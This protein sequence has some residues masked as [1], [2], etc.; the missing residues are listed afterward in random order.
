MIHRTVIKSFIIILA[1]LLCTFYANAGLSQTESSG[2]YE[3]IGE[4]EVSRDLSVE[5]KDQFNRTVQAVINHPLTPLV[6]GAI[7]V[8]V[9][10]VLTW[11]F[12]CGKVLGKAE[13]GYKFEPK[14]DA[15]G[16]SQ[17]SLE[18]VKEIVSGRVSESLPK[19][20]FGI[21]FKKLPK[22]N[23]KGFATPRRSLWTF[24]INRVD[25]NLKIVSKQIDDLT[26]ELKDVS[27]NGVKRSLRARLNSAFR[28][29]KRLENERETLTNWLEVNYLREQ[30][31]LDSDISLLTDKLK[32]TSDNSSLQDRFTKQLQELEARK[33]NLL[34]L[35]KFPKALEN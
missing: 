25:E 35:M 24:R 22:P 10:C 19:P 28:L 23:F 30:K 32:N 13:L 14:L 2:D 8:G 1:L 11:K 9:M 16:V 5:F 34:E 15:N 12:F 3:E 26:T 6:S 18:S 33:A 29:K 21:H 27:D 31:I 7:G 20:D 4:V 17:N